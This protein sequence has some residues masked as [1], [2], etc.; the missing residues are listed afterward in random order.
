M[1]NYVVL[2]LISTINYFERVPHVK[3]GKMPPSM[4]PTNDSEFTYMYTKKRIFYH[5]SWDP[6]PLHIDS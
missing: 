2:A 5:F 6:S 4:K 3:I 1:Q